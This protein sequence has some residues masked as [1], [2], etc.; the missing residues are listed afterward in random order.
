LVEEVEEE[1]A[2]AVKVV[3]ATPEAEAELAAGFEAMAA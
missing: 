1:A 2:P 3:T